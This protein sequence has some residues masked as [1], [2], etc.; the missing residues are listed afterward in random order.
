MNDE[1]KGLI[2]MAGIVGFV[3]CLAIAVAQENL[4]AL[5][6]G[7]LVLIGTPAALLF[8]NPVEVKLVGAIKE[9]TISIWALLVGFL[10]LIALIIMAIF[11]PRDLLDPYRYED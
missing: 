10:M 8:V 5:L 2:F 7:Y 1:D 4:T 9:R 3:L 11:G 6:I